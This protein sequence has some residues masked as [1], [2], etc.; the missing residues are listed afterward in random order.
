MSFSDTSRGWAVG[1]FAGTSV[2][3]IWRTTNGGLTW[4]EKQDEERNYHGTVAQNAIR[5]ITCGNV[6]HFSIDTALVVRTTTGGASWQEQRFGQL[7]ALRQV[8][9]TDSV[10][11]WI[12]S[13]QNSILRT[14]DGGAT[15]QQF[16]IPV[17]FQSISFVN[18]STGWGT[19][20]LTIYRTT[21]AGENWELLYAIP[22]GNFFARS[23]SFSDSLNGL[24]FGDTFHLGGDA[25]S[26]YRTTD[27]GITWQAEYLGTVQEYMSAGMMLDRWHG[28]AVTTSGRV[29]GYYRTTAVA[30]RLTRVPTRFYLR[31]NYPNPFNSTTSIEY[32]LP[33]HTR[34]SLTIY[35]M[36]GKSIRTLVD[37]TQ[38]PGVYRVQFTA[39]GLSSG[40]YMYELVTSTH[41]ETQHLT[42]LK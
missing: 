24:L 42:F 22:D 3:I 28:W 2:G 37:E 15:W 26:I 23:I 18:E 34:V 41:K 31:Q 12:S 16:P 8:V 7:T 32:A 36:L 38:E 39:T 27:G 10:R 33:E 29:Y 19:T 40:S 11:G 25:V 21:D 17:H 6:E 5:N 20:N 14:T 9:F 30:E 35:D 4:T 13:S 1:F